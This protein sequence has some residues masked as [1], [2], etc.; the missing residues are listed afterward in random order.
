MQEDYINKK[1]TLEI[2]TS[3]LKNQIMNPFALYQNLCSIIFDEGDSTEPLLLY[4]FLFMIKG[5]DQMDV[6][7]LRLDRGF[8]FKKQKT[9][10]KELGK[11]P[12][13][14]HEVSPMKFETSQQ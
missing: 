9:Y 6:I 7:H 5:S 4:I 8:R 1:I 2:W 14:T 3:E 10:N 11:I 13:Y 12:R